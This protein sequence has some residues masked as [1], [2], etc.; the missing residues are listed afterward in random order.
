MAQAANKPTNDEALEMI[1]GT[2]RE[3]LNEMLDDLLGYVRASEA[4][5]S[6]TLKVSIAPIKELPDAYE[7]SVVPSLAVKGTRTDGKA[8]ITRIGNQ[9]QLILG[10]LSIR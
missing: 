5:G 10:G 6:I 7:V 3:R 4:P 8:K 1:A 2:C 9:L